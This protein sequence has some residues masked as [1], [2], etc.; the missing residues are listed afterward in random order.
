MGAAFSYVKQVESLCCLLQQSLRLRVK[1][2]LPGWPLGVTWAPEPH[3]RTF[4]S[5]PS[6]A[7][8]LSVQ[9]ALWKGEV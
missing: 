3:T 8:G 6:L 1:K 4:F 9:T 7:S 2:Q 5:L